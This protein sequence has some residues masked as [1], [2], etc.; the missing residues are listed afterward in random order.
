MRRHLFRWN[1][2]ISLKLVF[3][4]SNYICN[5][6]YRVVTIRKKREGWKGAEGAADAK[7]PP[8]CRIWPRITFRPPRPQMV[9]PL[10]GWFG[11]RI[12]RRESCF[13]TLH[14]ALWRVTDSRAERAAV[15]REGTASDTSPALIKPPSKPPIF[16]HNQNQM[17]RILILRHG[18]RKQNI[19]KLPVILDSTDFFSA[20]TRN[21][22]C[23]RL[24]GK[25]NHWQQVLQWR[26]SRW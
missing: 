2:L 6:I 8:W 9:D 16:L 24:N 21:L 7:D 4:G 14:S 17:R 18:G 22:S 13:A 3:L 23:R 11:E 15:A 5:H 10:V 19:K 20:M 1:S 25:S 12:Y 26:I